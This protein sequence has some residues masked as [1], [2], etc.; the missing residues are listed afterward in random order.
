M[1]TLS[2]V[3]PLPVEA[4]FSLRELTIDDAEELYEL[5]SVNR[6]YL[7]PWM[8]WAAKQTFED[9]VQFLDQGR[10]QA[11]NGEGAQLAVLDGAAIAGV[12]GFHQ[13]DRDKR[14][15]GIGYWIDEQHQGRGIAT[16]AVW[17][18]C[19]YAF[20]TWDLN[21]IE[22]RAA[23]ANTPSQKL[24]KRLSFT[25]EGTLREAEIVN[26]VRLDCALY[27]VLA[28]EWPPASPA[29]AE[30]PSRALSIPCRHVKLKE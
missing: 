3:D 12:I 4:S 10:Q 18:A 9:T 19:D 8:P 14:S 11:A 6:S 7:S 22:I 25:R 20:S 17:A 30:P 2:A 27:S 15:V 13:I 21:R 1:T 16:K 24:A 5:I 28:A 26:E 29:P 23:L